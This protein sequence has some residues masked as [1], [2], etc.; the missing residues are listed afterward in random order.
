MNSTQHL[1]ESIRA[2]MD[3][4]GVSFES[5]AARLGCSSSNV[6]QLLEHRGKTLQVATAERL[7]GALG[8]TL[9]LQLLPNGSADREAPPA[10][11][12]AAPPEA[13]CA[14][15]AAAPASPPGRHRRSAPPW[16]PSEKG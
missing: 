16:R 8:C 10:S 3:R 5:L 2:E 6:R 14:G 11:R 1:V 12:S 15:A 9:E 13:E 4:Q 7:A